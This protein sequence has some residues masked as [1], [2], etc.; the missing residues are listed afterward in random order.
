MLYFLD[1]IYANMSK[2]IVNV[3]VMNFALSDHLPTFAV[4]R[5]FK[6]PKEEKH[7]T[8]KYHNF[9]GINI[10]AFKSTLVD[11]PWDTVFIFDDIDDSL[12][13]WEELFFQAVDQHAP[14]KQKRV[15]KVNQPHWL[16][17]EILNQLS[18]RDSLLKK[19]FSSY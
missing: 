17:K 5:Y 13:A 19:R 14:V 12:A 2:N 6:E 4:R 7:N 8:I 3:T 15:R 1:H 16:T 10:E 9:K 18:E 11:S